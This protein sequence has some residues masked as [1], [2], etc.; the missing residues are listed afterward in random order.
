MPRGPRLDGVEVLHHVMVRGIERRPIFVNDRDREDFCSRLGDLALETETAIYAWCLIP[1][2]FHLLLRS[3]SAPLSAFM[4]R[5]LTGYAVAFNRRHRRTG[6]L[7]QNRFK[8]IVV[9]EEPYLL[10]L[11]RYIHLNPVRARLVSDLAALDDFEWTGHSFLI[12]G[13]ALPWQDATFVLGQFGTTP[14][15]A[16]QR[17]RRFVSEGVSRGQ[18][19]ELTGGG[20]RRSRKGWEFRGE[21]NGGRERWAADERILGSSDFVLRTLQEL[22]PTNR[23][24]AQTIDDLI[25]TAARQH[26]V[27]IEEIRSNS[28]RPPVVAARARV[29]YVA[30]CERGLTLSAVARLLGLSRRSAARA[31][32]RAQHLGCRED[33]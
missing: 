3:G 25:E 28:H 13:R 14:R 16:R 30:V 24:G 33:V 22:T 9:E 4:R 17:Y 21:V 2:H 11:V 26:R 5:L 19:P 7:F 32:E 20:L 29:T 1:N 15:V 23:Q 27:G 31:F 10:E 6:H 8:S 12:G 18:R